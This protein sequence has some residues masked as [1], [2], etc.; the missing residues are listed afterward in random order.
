MGTFE[1]N[2]STK[3][4]RDE[5][6]PSSWK[7]T[8]KP[9]G[10]STGII[11]SERPSLHSKACILSLPSWPPHGPSKSCVCERSAWICSDNHQS[12]RWTPLANLSRLVLTIQN[13]L[14]PRHSTMK[15]KI[16][17]LVDACPHCSESSRRGASRYVEQDK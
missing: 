9:E 1:L 12:V 3:S 17:S 10:T 13:A 15:I 8:I 7:L 14:Y 6:L 4:S 2:S 11:V 16:Q 5:G